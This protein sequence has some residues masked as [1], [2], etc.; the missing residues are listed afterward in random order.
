MRREELYV[1]DLADNTRAIREYLDGVSREQWDQDRL[2]RDA[3]LYLTTAKQTSSP[4]DLQDVAFSE[5]HTQIR[6]ADVPGG[7]EPLAEAQHGGCGIDSGHAGTPVCGGT[8]GCP[9]LTWR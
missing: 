5:V 3:V 2:R 1:A 9:S 4:R 8:C 7:G 6:A